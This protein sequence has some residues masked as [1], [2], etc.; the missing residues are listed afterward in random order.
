MN[1]SELLWYK[2]PAENWDEALPVGNGRIGGMIFGRTSDEL[3][4]L[5]EDSIWSGGFRYRNNSKSLDNLEKIRSLIKE[6]RTTEAEEVCADAFYGTNEQQRHYKPMGDLHIWQNTGETTDYRRTLDLSNAVSTVEFTADGVKYKREIFISHKDEVMAALFTADKSGAV[7]FTAAI[8]GVDDYYDKNEAYDESTLLFTVSDGIPYATAISV[9]AK[10]GTACT[11][12]NRIKVSGA[13]SAVLILSCRTAFRGADYEKQAIGDAK[14]ALRRLPTLKERHIE[15][16]RSLYGRC[17]LHLNDNSSGASE[18]PTKER[19][20]RIRGGES[21][22]GIVEMYFNF[23]RYLMI[24]GSREGTLPLNLQGI[25]NKDM[26]PAWGGKYTININ[27]EMNY[28]GAEIQNLSECHTPLF[29][30]IERMR[31]NGRVTA[32]KMYGCRGTVCHHNT[33]IWGD[34][35][36]QDKWM[37]A[38]LWPMGMAWLCLHI[39]EHYKFTQD[40]DF[41]AEKYDTLREAA[42]FFEDYLIENDDGR[43]VTCPSVSPENT[44]ITKTGEKGTLCIGPSMD[45]EI[46]YELFTAVAESADILGIDSDYAAKMRE[47][48]SRLPE[49]KIGKYGQIMEWAEDYDEVEPGH[50]HISQLFALYPADMISSGKTPELAK[51]ARAT[52]ERRLSYGG[53][54]T[55]WSRAWIINMWARL[56]DGEKVGENISALLSNSTS[57]NMFDMHPPFQIDGNF[58]GG[59]GIA[60]ALL[61]SSGGEIRL[62]PALPPQWKSGSV[63]GMKARGGFEISFEWEN[64]RVKSAVISSE[65]GGLCNFYS[66]A[67]IEVYKNGKI[68]EI[69]QNGRTYTFTLEKNDRCEIKYS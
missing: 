12:C 33:D 42:E 66:E 69:L 54:H 10:G 24:S 63:R 26:W 31:E 4:Q 7:S 3:I 13:D 23:S 56:F 45:S 41:L 6:G 50:R 60:E 27:T 48:R 39:Y 40:K 62:L 21:D 5:N 29:D 28:W 64:C 25:W 32:R 44:Y 22:N 17:E 65:K 52:M 35:A 2:K 49:L 16:Y 18:L 37:P 43:L 67:P 11:D 46:L 59:A 68:A 47:M 19:L 34:T 30:H 20:E 1:L 38:T 53:G 9:S 51:A 36:P 61:Q 15:D 58:G 14:K 8:D 55:G 57:I